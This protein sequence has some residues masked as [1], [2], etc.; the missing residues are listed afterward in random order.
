MTTRIAGTRR[1]PRP[2]VVPVHPLGRMEERAEG[3]EAASLGPAQGGRR[4]SIMGAPAEAKMTTF[5]D[6]HAH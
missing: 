6:L 1:L 2:M 4:L 3:S 5:A